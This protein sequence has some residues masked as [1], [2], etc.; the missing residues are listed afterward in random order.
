MIKK[1]P[2][3]ISDFERINKESYYYVD[4]TE[5][6]PILESMPS[7]IFFIRPRRFGKSLWLSILASYYDI[8]K[9]DQFEEIFK[10]TYIGEHPTDEKNLYLILYFNF[11]LVNPDTRFVEESFASHCNTRI[12]SFLE[13]YGKYF[14]ESIIKRINQ[15]EKTDE[16]LGELF[17]YSRRKQLNIYGFIDEY[18]NF[19]NTVLSS[20]GRKNYEKLTRGTG[21]FRFFFNMFKGGTSGSGSAVAKL[22]ITGVSPITMDDVTS[23]FNIGKNLS[24]SPKFNDMMG[25]TEED[26][27]KILNYYKNAGLLKL[28]INNCLEIMKLWYN[29]YRFSERSETRMF[30]PDM[31]LYFISEIIEQDLLPENLID[32]NIRIDYKKLQHLVVIDK[33]LNGNFSRLKK[34]SESGE[35]AS[36]I[37]NSFPLE[38][39]NDRENFISLLFYFGLLTIDRTERNQLILCIPNMTVKHLMYGYLRDAYRDVDI[40]RVDLWELSN[41]VSNMAYEGKWKPVFD[42]FTDEIEKQTAIRDYLNGE[43][44]IQGFLL[45]YLN[46]TDLYLTQTEQDMQKGFSDLY[47]E[48][49]SAKY[50]D[51]GFAYLIELKYISRG[52]YSETRLK[53]EIKQA[54]AQINQY[55]DSERIRKTQGNTEL[56]KII[57]IYKGWELVYR[58][59]YD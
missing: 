17:E 15:A 1:I 30:N 22:F 50:P 12:Y 47:L 46:I 40:F 39:L 11:S 49:F 21:F 33:K 6:I 38:R 28:N 27:V 10:N 18:D 20:K 5:F 25:F 51:M 19:S 58:E 24:R 44:V 26:V 31:V 48:P 55:A 42:F 4:K 41:L 57:L 3:G 8:N 43:K 13:Q 16:K 23:G 52:K 35:I 37:K 59:E 45:A 53:K 32:Q 29:N 7:F 54:E 56:K 9:K 36:K 2:Y 34:I 14:D